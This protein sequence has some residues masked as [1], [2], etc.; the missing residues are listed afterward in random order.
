MIWNKFIKKLVIFV[1]LALFR[2]NQVKY[3]KLQSKKNNKNF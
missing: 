3:G 1:K 2:K